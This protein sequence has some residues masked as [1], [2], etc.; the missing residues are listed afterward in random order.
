MSGIWH[1]DDVH[2]TSAGADFGNCI[3]AKPSVVV[4]P[5]TV[6]DVQEALRYTAARNLSLA[7][8]GSGHSTYGQCQADG[9]VVLDMKRFNTVHDVRSGQATIDAGVRWSDVVA[10]TLS[11]QQTPPVLTDYLGTTV[12]GTLSVGGFGGSSHGFGLQTDNVDSLAVVTGSGDFRECSAVSNSELFDAVRGGLGQFGVIVNATIRLTA[13]HESVRQYKL[14]YSNLGVFLGDQL[15]A[16]SNRLFDHVQGRIRVDADG[17]L[18]YRLD[19]AKYFTPP[20]RPDDD[21]LLSSL[22]YDSCAEYNSDVDYGDFI[23]RMADQEL[24]LRHTGEWFYPHPWASLLIPADKIEQFIETTSS[25][26][27]DDL[28]NSGLIMVYPIPTTP[29]TAPFIPIPHCDTFFMLA[30][31][32][33]ASPGAEARMIASNRLLYEQAR[34]VGGVA[35][36]VNAVPMSPGDW[37]THFGSR[38]QAIARAKRRFDPYRILAPGYRMSFD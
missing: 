6:A 13:A 11:R 20:R 38:W 18:R 17:H 21:A 4:V 33:T 36:A 25:S 32:R 1:T 22:Q 3:H 24:D 19:L 30:V 14:Q 10:A 34:D 37:C 29:I 2:L 35:Y 16:M 27:T 15:R 12:G 31:L 5:R 28:G 26:L 7:V 23:N 8:R 9:G